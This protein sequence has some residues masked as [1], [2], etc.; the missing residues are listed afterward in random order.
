MLR[1]SLATLVLVAPLVLVGCGGGGGGGGDAPAPAPETPTTTPSTSTFPAAAAYRMYVAAAQQTN[2]TLSP[3]GFCSGTATLTENVPTAATFE[4]NPAMRKPVTW[5]MRFT[6]C[7]PSTLT[8]TTEIFLDTNSSQVGESSVGEGYA[9]LDRPLVLPATVKVG[10]MGTLATATVY[11]DNTKATQTAT[12]TYSYV[13][14][15]DNRA[16]AILVKLTM[17]MTEALG[18]EGSEVRTYRITATGAMTLTAVTLTT[19]GR[20]LILTAN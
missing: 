5:V 16:D 6:N 9:V 18:T 10:D 12:I 14:E 15:A 19:P 13:A 2:F 17:R 11:S 3:L 1:S 8:D 7:V 4:G 20:R